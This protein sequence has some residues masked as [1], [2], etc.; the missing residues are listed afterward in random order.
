MRVMM[1]SGSVVAL[2]SVVEV[3]FGSAD[4]IG[5]NGIQAN[6]LGLTGM[7]ISIGQVERGRPGLPSFDS[8]ANSNVSITPAAVFLRDGAATA[9]SSNV[10]THAE[11][12]AGV[13]ISTDV[14][15]RGVA[16]S[17]SLYSSAYET[18]GT[19]PGYDHA[20]LS[21]QHVATQNGGDVRAI[22]HSWGKPLAGSPNFDGNAQLTAGLDWSAR[23]HDVLHVVSGNQGNMIPIPKDN[24]N[25][26]T[27]ASSM[28]N[29]GVYRQVSTVNTYTEDAFGDRT[30][31]DLL[32]PG[33]DIEV[34]G[35]GGAV[36]TVDGTS[37]AAPHVTGT[38][39]LLQE[40]ADNQITTVG[41]PR[42]DA[43]AR[44]HEVMKAVLMN[45]ADKLED[46]GDGNRLGMTRT[47]IKKNGS[48][49][50]LTSPAATDPTIPLDEEFGAGHLNARRALKQ[51]SPGEWDPNSGDV[52]VIGWDFDSTNSVNTFRRYPIG[53]ALRAGSRIS[54]TLAWDR[55]VEFEIDGGTPGVFD[56]GDT[57]EAY[58]ANLDEQ[59]ND[60]DLILVDRGTLD[61]VPGGFSVGEVNFG[62][63]NLEH[64]FFEIPTTGQYD[65]IVN[66]FDTGIAFPLGPQTYGL[67][68]WG[69]TDA[70]RSSG[71]FNGDGA[72][73]G[74]DLFQWI[75]DYGINGF[76]DADGDGDSDGFDFLRWQLNVGTSAPLVA[77][78]Q[79]VPEPATWLLLAMGTLV[80]PRRPGSSWSRMAWSGK[81]C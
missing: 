18:F 20:L 78:S 4:S 8:P 9:N 28:K 11:Q 16:T 52:P 70:L 54:M 65:I 35:L 15:R 13:L 27:I 7:G 53:P 48:D 12:V 3:A 63:F 74:E 34:T 41:A 80:V 2:F 44:R 24:F 62:G 75:G 38:V 31:I 46:I 57:F 6:G 39:A 69:V 37:F 42:W 30:S 76:S 29:G 32:A 49:T 72:G 67:A 10:A 77:A 59:M 61:V 19:S 45:S 56:V 5:P 22:N 50:W 64:M 73:N 79:A 36:A 71:D 43:E 58:G 23:E 55:L 17:A 25:G 1:F 14:I 40:F 26:M 47:V 51:F 81:R 68:W 21:I 66:H 33:E 60:L